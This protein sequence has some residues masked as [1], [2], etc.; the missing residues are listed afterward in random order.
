[1]M[2]IIGVNHLICPNQT[3]DIQARFCLTFMTGKKRMP[4]K[5]EMMDELEEDLKWRREKGYP[6][7]KFH[8]LGGDIL[9]EYYRDLADKADLEPIQPIIAQMH[10]Q[11][12]VNRRT[13]YIGFHDYKFEVVDE[14]NFKFWKI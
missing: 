10:T 9:N 14:N 8:H 12:L 7:K 3:F 11:S 6:E 13:D 4:T 5:A 2:G 1:M